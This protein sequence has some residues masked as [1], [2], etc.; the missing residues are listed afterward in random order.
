MMDANADWTAKDGKDLQEFMIASGLVD[1]LVHKFGQE[2][3]TM[4]TYARGKRRIDFIFMQCNVLV[5]LACMK[6][7]SH[8]CYCYSGL[9]ATD[10]VHNIEAKVKS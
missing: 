9:R 2:G 6:Q 5:L 7:C 1:P 4:A 10:S 8:I 3:V